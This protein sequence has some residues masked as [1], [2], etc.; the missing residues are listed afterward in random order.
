[1]S[2]SSP[3][4]RTWRRGASS[5]TSPI[6]RGHRARQWLPHAPG[7]D[8]RAPG[9]AGPLLGE[10]DDEVL[11]EAG[12]TPAEREALRAAGVTGVARG[13]GGRS[14]GRSEGGRLRRQP[15][16]VRTP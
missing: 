10:H 15:R 1:M 12:L 8:P 11:A 6:P 2:T 16:K 3:P 7:S 4:I 14:E 5:A 9:A 13:S